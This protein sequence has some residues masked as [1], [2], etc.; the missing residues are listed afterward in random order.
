MVFATSLVAAAMI[1]TPSAPS[2]RLQIHKSGSKTYFVVTADLSGKKLSA[3]VSFSSQLTSPWNLL[4]DQPFAGI[5]G[6]FFNPRTGLP[7]GDVVV[8][9]DARN[10]GLR[11]SAVAIDWFGQVNIID[12][13]RKVPV[14]WRLYRYAV[15]GVVRVLTN[16][17]LMPNP[18]AQGFKDR[19]LW[20]SAARTGLGVTP[21]GKVIFVA[22]KSSVTLSE[23]GR[24]MKKYGAD[25][26]VSLD[27]GGSTC[28]YYK[29]KFVVSTGR[30]LSNLVLLHNRP[31]Y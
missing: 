23:L 21:A 19:R 30:R 25:D 1:A 4:K 7:V 17:Q 31:P 18:K 5:T 9:G 10:W 15:R 13:R 22:T 27:G 24:V 28:L 26:A 6:T 20:G 16:G 29:G 14:D 12:T 2:T 8:D 11:G 3:S